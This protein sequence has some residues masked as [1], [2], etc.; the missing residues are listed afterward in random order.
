[1]I[2]ST[3][4]DFKK[5]KPWGNFFFFCNNQMGH[6]VLLEEVELVCCCATTGKIHLILYSISIH[7]KVSKNIT[8][9]QYVMRRPS[10]A[11]MQHE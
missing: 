5:I 1:M 7:V 11:S 9:N 2:S 6:L 8:T 3:E 4:I 10:N